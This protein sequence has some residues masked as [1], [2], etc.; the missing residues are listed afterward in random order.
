MAFEGVSLI[1]ASVALI[2]LGYFAYNA[3]RLEVPGVR[4]VMWLDWGSVLIA[5]LVFWSAR[6]PRLPG[7]WVHAA[8]AML[9][10]SV[11]ADTAL[12]AVIYGEGSDLE[13]LIA[14]AIGGAAITIS[15][16][17]YAFILLTTGMF[18]VW[19]AYTVC[20]RDEFIDTLVVQ[21]G[22]STVGVVIFLSRVRWLRKLLGFRLRD[23]RT[24]HDLK[25]A[26]ARAEREFQEHQAIERRQHE[27]VE[28]LRQAQKLEALGTLAGGVAH[29]INNVIGAITA[30][31]STTV[32]DLPS[33]AQGRRELQQILAAARR[34]TTLTRNLIRF[35]RQDQPV[36]V[37]F[38]LDEVVAEVE[39]LLRRT[40]GKHVELSADCQCAGWAVIGDAGL[41]SHV[42]MNLCLNAADAIVERGEISIRTRVLEMVAGEARA[43]GVTPGDYLELIV[44]DNGKGMAPEV[45]DRAFEP[46]FSTKESKRRS[47]LGLPMVYGTVQQHSG[48]LKVESQ[49]GVGT[50]VRV[51]L[52][53]VPQSVIEVQRPDSIPL[54]DQERSFALFVDDEPLLRRAGR[55]MLT[56]LGYQAILA[57]NGKDALEQFVKFRERIGVVVLDVAMPV[58]S[59]V[60]CFERIREMDPNLPI[61]LASG[62]PKGHDLQPL[63][64]SNKT[65]YLRKPYELEE[66]SAALVDLQS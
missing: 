49:S 53:A 6:T 27:L 63:L 36:H 61:V 24:T 57:S 48:G 44:A 10:L 23:A 17:W 51:V 5:A 9:A 7:S 19:A 33:G 28:Q 11:A 22:A 29:D 31:A 47:G 8:G 42:V 54:I 26:L 56:V 25:Q 65:R 1:A 15:T 13:Y 59:G 43:M 4:L 45:L 16:Y 12:S 46:F 14:V 62:F 41:I 20:P 37:P 52:P 3:T 21:F 58:M 55:R 30:I 60:E 32:H 18:G 40:I 38:N 66:L 35:A 64:L 39:A 34:G 50:S 2:Y